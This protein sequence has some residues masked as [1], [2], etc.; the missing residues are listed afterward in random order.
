MADRYWVG[1]TGNWNTTDTS[2]WSATSGGA[3]GA[4]VPATG[5]NVFFDS[6]SNGSS[7]TVTISANTALCRDL[8]FAAPATGNVT[9][10]GAFAL[11]ISGSLTLY[12]G[13]TR[14][15]SGS[16]TFSANATGKTITLAG[17]TLVSVV[18][19]NGTGGGWTFQDAFTTTNSVSLDRG[20]LDT[21]GQAVSWGTFDSSNGNTRSLTLG[22]S[23]ITMTNSVGLTWNTGN[24]SGMTFSAG[25]ST[26]V[27]NTA[28]GS[29]TTSYIFGNIALNNLT[30]A[31]SSGYCRRQLQ[32]SGVTVN[33]TLTLTGPQQGGL[34]RLYV[35]TN[36]VGSALTITVNGSL[37][38]T[39]VDFEDITAAGT[40]G[41][42]TGTSLGNCGGCSGITFTGAVTRYWV[43]GTGNLYDNA[44]FSATSGGAGGASW[45]L[46]QDTIVFDA[47][48]FTAG[49]LTVT[50]GNNNIRM[51]TLDFT[52]ATNNPTLSFNAN[53]FIY[54]SLILKS[55]MAWG[56]GSSL[57]FRGRGSHSITSAG[58]TI[59][60]ILT[61]ASIGGT[62]TVQGSLTCS[63]VISLNNGTLDTNSQTIQSTQFSSSNSNTRALTMGST[64]WTLTASGTPWS[65]ATSTNFT[66]T[67]GTSTIK[68][69]DASASA[70]TFAGGSKT[71]ANIWLTGSGT[72][73]FDFTGSNTFADFKVDTPPHTIRFT[74]GT[75]TTVTT[76]T[77]SGTAGNLMTIGSI[78]ASGHNLAKA[79]G[80]V[81]SCDY[82]SISRSTASPG[83]TWYAGANSTDGGNNSGWIFTAPPP[84]VSINKKS[85]MIMF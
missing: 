36:V 53:G 28:T 11:N 50:T 63:S 58:I 1:G 26:L 39:N 72:G 43:G 70:K 24:L 49:G 60:S 34:G 21:N 12:S 45:P 9:W 27:H 5:D 59:S 10:A 13:M 68:F 8:T 22:A 47:N 56:S 65:C 75:T 85:Q 84:P 71:Y 33:G 42:W 41:T 78:T 16:I 17:N 69:T 25:T 46:P 61:I 35:F 44:E 54:G 30:F 55:G 51:P 2:H 52:N 66:V 18:A 82:L 4:S 73:T 74:A 20:A 6:A 83:T 31:P 7:Y 19:F 76:F 80:G 81:I 62:Y 77:V 15:Y 3:S 38:L 37:S 67:P 48:S 29:N 14:S 40:V 79:G 64:T 57:E 32:S 23:T